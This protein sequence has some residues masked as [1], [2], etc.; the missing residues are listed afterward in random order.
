MQHAFARRPSDAQLWLTIFTGMVATVGGLLSDL[1]ASY[2]RLA[3]HREWLAVGLF[4]LISCAGVWLAVRKEYG[5]WFPLQTLIPSLDPATRSELEAILLPLM[6][7][8]QDRHALLLLAV[9]NDRVY[10]QI[11]FTGAAEPFTLN[12]I[13]VLIQ[14]GEIAQGKQVLWALL[15][16]VAE[17]VG[18]DQQQRIEALRPAILALSQSR[19]V[20]DRTTLSTAV[21][22]LLKRIKPLP[23]AVFLILAVLVALA[24]PLITK[25]Y[26]QNVEHCLP[27]RVCVLVAQFETEGEPTADELTKKIH[28]ALH[29]AINATSPDRFTVWEPVSLSKEKQDGESPEQTIR[30]L[31]RDL[32][33]SLA[34]WG[35]VYTHLAPQPYADVQY[36]S[37]DPMG[38]AEASITQPYRAVPLGYDALDR[39]CNDCMIVQT[40]QQSEIVAYAVSGLF[41]YVRHRPRD[42]RHAFEAALYCAGKGDD[43]PDLND[44]NPKPMCVPDQSP[45]NWDAG[46][47]YYYRGKA[48][49]LEGDF[50][51]AVADLEKAAESNRDDPAAPAGIAAAY[52]GWLGAGREHDPLV[53]QV[54]DQ[55]RDRALAL[56]E[57]AGTK[58]A[59]SVQYDLGFIHE[60]AGEYDLARERYRMAA[61]SFSTSEPEDQ[62]ESPYVSL[63]ALAR[64]QQKDGDLEAARASLQEALEVDPDLS[65]AY[66]AIAQSYADDPPTAK[67]WLEKAKRRVYT[68][69]AAVDVAEAGLCT[70]WKDARCAEEA[71]QRALEKWPGYGNLYSLVGDFYRE[72][73]DW[74]SA[75]I[76]YAT[77]AERLRPND[78]WAHERLAYV[79]SRQGKFAESATEYQQAIDLA[80]S[81]E[82]VPDGVYCAMAL[83]QESAGDIRGAVDSYQHCLE[84]TTDPARRKAAEDK[85]VELQ[86]RK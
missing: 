33:A 1:V 25:V 9:G 37:A 78:P 63:I 26:A 79:L 47:L 62:G 86:N 35:T 45:P 68:F 18:F 53:T 15:E 28:G 16:V 70:G 38:I 80:F 19:R 23:V 66:I 17:R 4:A 44:L 24:S 22:V 67:E 61:E 84:S 57:N 30:R 6:Q 10:G 32:G 65:W 76:Y 55:A 20:I 50:K 27:D 41:H 40:S 31:V 75:R 49:Y 60:L 29:R 34:V 64:V 52:Q 48:F 77:P 81:A 54:L 3:P 51:R 11:D 59:P 21:T 42:A 2:L 74:N 85:I 58:T 43:V 83:A 71:F 73:G 82:Y 46:L 36:F 13:D 39:S 56:L 5:R 12:M 7:E 72:L 69:D 8:E 14:R